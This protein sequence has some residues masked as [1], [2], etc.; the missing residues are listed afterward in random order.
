MIKWQRKWCRESEKFVGHEKLEEWCTNV[1]TPMTPG[2]QLA[3]LVHEGLRLVKAPGR[4][5]L[6]HVVMARGM[7][8]GDRDIAIMLLVTLHS[9][10][11]IRSWSRR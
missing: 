1:Y 3:H 6:W 7:D 4:N 9:M 8:H 11:L 2:T 10:N 5:I